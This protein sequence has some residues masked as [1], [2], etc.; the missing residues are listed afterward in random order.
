MGIGTALFVLGPLSAWE[1]EDVDQNKGLRDL[2]NFLRYFLSQSAAD[3]V[4]AIWEALR[5]DGQN[6]CGTNRGQR[7]MGKVG[8]DIILFDPS[9]TAENRQQVLD[10]LVFAELASIGKTGLEWYQEYNR[11]LGVLGWSTLNVVNISTAVLTITSNKPP[12]NNIAVDL[13]LLLIREGLLCPGTTAAQLVQKLQLQINT[14][15]PIEFELLW[16]MT[17]TVRSDERFSF[18]VGLVT[19]SPNSGEPVLDLVA[20]KVHDRLSSR[21]TRSWWSSR[22][23]YYNFVRVGYDARSLVGNKEVYRYV[24]AQLES[25]VT[26]FLSD[27]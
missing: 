12:P 17:Q 15:D 5:S 1:R 26:A 20:F 6:G 13:L 11:A 27:V 19:E 25:L 3:V 14:M 24:Q 7:G 22:T 21:R 18:R 2:Q 16:L 4:E 8:D 10:S 23:T 9:V